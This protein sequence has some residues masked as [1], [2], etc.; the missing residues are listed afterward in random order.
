MTTSA[1]RT[2]D[3]APASRR[4]PMRRM[5]VA[6]RAA[7]T[8]AL[9]AANVRALAATVTLSPSDGARVADTVTVTAR[10]A[11][12][13]E[14]GVRNVEFLVDG[15]PRGAD[16]S[17]PY[18]L[19]WDTLSDAEGAHKIEAVATDMQGNS[20]RGE[21]TLTVD[22]ELG[23]GA[24]HHARIALDA[25]REKDTDRAVRHARRAIKVDATNL[26][27]ARA[28]SGIYRASKDYN[29][30]IAV[31]EQAGIPETEV[32]VRQELAALY[33]L[34]GDAGET[35][36]SLLMGASSALDQY[37][38][39]AKA[40]IAALQADATPEQRG[41][42]AFAVRDWSG[43]IK[44]YQ[45]AGDPATASLGAVN[46][47][48]LAY[49]MAG[50]RRDCD[51]LLRTLNR[52]KRGDDVTRAVQAYHLL[53]THKPKDARAIV[54]SGVDNRLLASL[55]VAASADLVLGEKK[56]AADEI[57]AA[58]EIA[59]NSAAILLLQAQVSQEPLD[60]RALYVAAIAADP[61]SPEV[62]VRK[63]FDILASKRPKYLEETE[64]MLEFARKADRDNPDALMATAA[65]FL[66]RSRPEE[67]QPIL[68][69]VLELAP[70]APD[71][72]VGSALNYSL[73]DQS[74]QI[75]ALLNRAMKIDEDLW[76]DVFVPK[77]LD[78]VTRVAK[79][80]MTPIL[81]PRS[82]YPTDSP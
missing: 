44:A 10:V 14:A 33:V 65:L 36:E 37:S 80:R 3:V 73:L 74:R 64:A 78:F 56:K 38:R 31:L 45:T 54:Q 62:Y 58:A 16:S 26:T 61:S 47:L 81:T 43:A 8:A 79:Y 70:D 28:L 48:L 59:P 76:N 39:A 35:L 34:R 60:V 82:L 67:A 57:A 53:R 27:A 49:S 25:L 30:A 24:E 72:L 18:T 2:T 52:E 1:C 66:L 21:A 22:N 55:L 68:A 12:F 40:R 5:R 9:L 11:G 71:A 7:L 51:L 63:A 46:R 6:A 77:P 75:T 20:A 13:E 17:I 42:A 50:R 19:E 29:K 32:E 69:R 23:K 41:D 15:K 4:Q